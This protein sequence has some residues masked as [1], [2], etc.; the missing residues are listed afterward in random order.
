MQGRQKSICP[1][2]NDDRARVRNFLPE[3]PVP[4]LPQGPHVRGKVSLVDLLLTVVVT[5]ALC[6]HGAPS[7]EIAYVGKNIEKSSSGL[8]TAKAFN[9]R[10]NPSGP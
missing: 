10:F 3:Y 2:G 6:P 9:S 4:L 7:V 8:S 1:Y 5:T